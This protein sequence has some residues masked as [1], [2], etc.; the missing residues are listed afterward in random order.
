MLIKKI[1]GESARL[2]TTQK[3]IKEQLK[4][5]KIRRKIKK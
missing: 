3:K 1:G 2:Q 5:N 4:K